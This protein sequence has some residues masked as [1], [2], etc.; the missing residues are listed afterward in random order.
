MASPRF[1]GRLWSMVDWGKLAAGHQGRMRDHRGQLI[2]D[3]TEREALAA[4][5]LTMGRH[6][7]GSFRIYV[8]AAD[9]ARVHLGAFCSIGT[10]V[11]FGVGGNHR[12]DWVT[13]YPFRAAWG[14]PG[15]HIDGHPRPE[16]DTVV[17]NDVWIGRD[18]L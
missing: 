6:S 7:Y 18:A 2:G 14:L 12:P 3:L 9:V 13:T 10:G 8:G 4:G 17:G 1:N 15:A 5:R 11:A 16:E